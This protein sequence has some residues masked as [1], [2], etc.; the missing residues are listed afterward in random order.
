MITQNTFSVFQ[1]ETPSNKGYNGYMLTIFNPLLCKE[2]A[3]PPNI[4][5]DLN[6]TED[7]IFSFIREASKEIP[8]QPVAR[9]AGGWIRDKLLGKPSKDVDITV[10]I[11]KGIEF[12]EYLKQFAV[13]RYGA[14]QNIIGTIKGTEAR[15]EQI[16][17]LAVAFL[18]IFGQ[19]VEILN[20]RANEVYEEGNRNPVSTEANVTAEQDAFRRDLTINSMNY[21]INTGRIEDFTGQGYDDLATMTLRTPLEPKKTLLD[22]PL[23]LLRILRFHSRYTSS[24][25]VPELV[26][27]MKDPNV[28]HQIVRKM[29][30]PQEERGIV[31]ERTAEEF[32]KIMMGNQ[33][34]E[35]IR[36][37]YNTGLLQKILNLPS[38]FHQ[39]D[40][41][42]RSKYHEMNVI[43][44]TLLVLKHM[45]Q[46]SQEFG[47]DDEQRVIMNISSL[48]HDLGK[49]DP[50][51]HKRKPDGTIGYSGDP[52][53]S[54]ALT[55]EQSSSDIF[56]TFA[57]SVGL[58]NK[59]QSTIGNLISSH[60]R[61]HDHVEGEARP[62]DKQL[63]KY[64]RKNPSWVFQYMHAMADTMS[65]GDEDE[66]VTQPYRN[67]LERLRM[68]A[69]SADSFGNQPP[70]QDLLNGTEII[71]MTG[72]SP[73]PPPGL[74]GYIN[75]VKE[76]INEAR[77]ENPNLIKE[78][79]IRIVQEMMSSGELNAYQRV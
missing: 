54:S 36:M 11:M 34:E 47:L 5:I 25:M 62:S 19:E 29:H 69:P 66:S 22:D 24:K 39:L 20:L 21:N 53:N 2:A 71:Q 10:D 3:L 49:L 17:N 42:Q 70:A 43:N 4:T 79:A 6:P 68:L 33:P 46:V 61:P 18:R 35:A 60:M 31:T 48:F 37:M 27:A 50:R 76:R 72:L 57:K 1:E 55:H 14:E 45:N 51:S 28:Q 15:P 32:R 63:R 52:S 59:E 40:M 38:S 77:D 9:V 67:N 65:K 23:R 41:D 75:V 30:D 8:G 64:I 73:Q 56:N 44:H 74:P 78:D 16:K 12:A 26:E 7:R 13:K 58:T